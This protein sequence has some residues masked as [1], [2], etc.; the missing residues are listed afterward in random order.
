MGKGFNQPTFSPDGQYVVTSFASP[1]PAQVG[2]VVFER[3]SSG[4]TTTAPN[5]LEW[6]SWTS[7]PG[8][9]VMYNTTTSSGPDYIMHLELLNIATG[10][11]TPLQPGSR[12]Y[13][14]A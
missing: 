8:V 11:H 9:A 5:G 14:W 7:Q 3:L 12:S 13:V 10:A 2:A 6:Q 4:A 1:T